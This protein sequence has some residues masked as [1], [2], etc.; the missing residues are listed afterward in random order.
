MGRRSREKQAARQQAAYERD[1]A[2]TAVSHHVERNPGAVVRCSHIQRTDLSGESGHVQSIRVDRS[3]NGRRV[4]VTYAA[5]GHH[6]NV[7]RLVDSMET[8]AAG[9]LSHDDDL[10]L[11]LKTHTEFIRPAE[12][13]AD[14]ARTPDEVR[15]AVDEYITERWDPDW[16]DRDRLEAEMGDGT[17]GH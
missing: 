7:S 4:R 12:R 2:R 13:S 10:G 8:V 15:A 9:D 11:S 3:G 16:P 5:Y 1:V 6:E 17:E 14:G